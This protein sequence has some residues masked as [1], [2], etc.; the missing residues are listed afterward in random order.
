MER[1]E[2]PLDGRI[3]TVFD[4][5]EGVRVAV[6][7]QSMVTVVPLSQSALIIPREDM[8]ALLAAIAEA[9]GTTLAEIAQGLADEEDIV[10]R[11]AD[12]TIYWTYKDWEQG[13]RSDVWLGTRPRMSRD[14]EDAFELADL[15][16][17]PE[18]LQVE[19]AAQFPDDEDKQRLAYAVDHGYVD[20][21]GLV[22]PLERAS[23][24]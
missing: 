1:K 2:V 22:D 5:P 14:D 12:V 20:E 19:Y 15:P 3:A 13:H 6:P 17:V 11:F 4:G 21:S 23:D 18:H 9:A 10:I 7:P 8:P 24:E 16:E